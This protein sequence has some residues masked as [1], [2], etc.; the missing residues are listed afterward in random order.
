[1]KSII[2]ITIDKFILLHQIKRF[3][4]EIIIIICEFIFKDLQKA[5]QNHKNKIYYLCIEIAFC[6]SRYNEFGNDSDETSDESENWI[7]NIDNYYHL[8]AINCSQCG[9]Y[10]DAI[11]PL[12]NNI[13]CFCRNYYHYKSRFHF[14]IDDY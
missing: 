3:P 7:F 14:N 13:V 12:N 8:Q 9:K 10:L 6:P 5:K 2:D 11:S 4:N 1:M